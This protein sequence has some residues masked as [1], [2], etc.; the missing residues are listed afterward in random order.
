MV[1]DDAVERG[2]RD[3]P[4]ARRRLTVR[5]RADQRR[6]AAEPLAGQPER[7]AHPAVDEPRD[8]AGQPL[9]QRRQSRRVEDGRVHVLDNPGDAVGR[10][11]GE[12]AEAEDVGEREGG[13]FGG[14]GDS[15]GRPGASGLREMSSDPVRAFGY[16]GGG[17]WREPTRRFVSQALHERQ[18][19]APTSGRPMDGAHCDSPNSSVWNG[20]HLDRR[21]SIQQC[22]EMR[23]NRLGPAEWVNAGLTP[24]QNP[25]LPRSRRTPSPIGSAFRAAASIGTSQ[26]V[27]AFHAA[28]LAA[29]A[30]SR[31]RASRIALTARQTI[32]SKPLLYRHFRPTRDRA[33]GAGLGDVRRTG[34]CG[35]RSGGRGANPTTSKILLVDAG[36]SPKAAETRARMMNWAYLGFAL[37]SARAD[38]AALRSFVSDLS[39][40][41]RQKTPPPSDAT[42]NPGESQ[43][44]RRR[45]IDS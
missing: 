40:L 25:D 22:M 12:A 33:R 39:Q 10:V 23:D 36:V 17:S 43:E 9:S 16:S 13:G 29:G 5:I 18:P 15:L 45:P 35:S 14:H 19:Q 41:V 3:F 20:Y 38:D 11:G 4:A 24:W 37:S 32:A 2:E 44:P 21:T 31:S 26:H 1:A 6:S 28:I 8:A 42:R 34:Q 27:A 7:A 30:R